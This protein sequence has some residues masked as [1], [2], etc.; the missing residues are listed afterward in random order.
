ME[1]VPFSSHVVKDED[2]QEKLV[3][4]G[5]DHEHPEKLN[6]IFVRGSVLTGQSVIVTQQNVQGKLV[7]VRGWASTIDNP[8]LITSGYAGWPTLPSD[9]KEGWAITYNITE[10]FSNFFS[11]TG[12]ITF[13]LNIGEGGISFFLIGPSGTDLGYALQFTWE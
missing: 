2:T 6:G 10:S 4:G 11:F 8:G 7:T 5:D 3:T 13:I 9:F 1:F 12:N